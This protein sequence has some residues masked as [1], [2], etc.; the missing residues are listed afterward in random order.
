MNKTGDEVVINSS[1]D[2]WNSWKN[3]TS[4]EQRAIDSTVVARKL[5][6]ESVPTVALRAIYVKG[7]FP[8]REMNQSSDVDMVPIVTETKFESDAFDVNGAEIHQ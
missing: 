7:S 6:I 4:I 1:F 5:V 8:R 3:I 2:F